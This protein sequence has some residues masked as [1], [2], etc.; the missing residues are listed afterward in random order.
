MTVLRARVTAGN[1]PT[2]V[3]MLGFEITDWAEQGVLADLTDLASKEGWDKVVPPALQKFSK[4]K[5]KW[6]AAP[7]NVHSTN[8]VWANKKMLRPAPA[9]AADRPGTSS[10]P[11]STRSRR[12]ATSR[13]RTA[14][15][16]G[17]KRPSSTVVVLPTGGPD[18]YR[19]AL[20]RSRPGRARRRPDEDG[21]R[22]AQGAG[23]VCRRQRCRAATGTSRPRWS[24]ATRPASRSWATGPRASSSTPRSAGQG[25][26]VLPLPGHAGDVS[27]NSDQFAMFN[28]GRASTGRRN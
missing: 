15:S 8:W 13:S 24:S 23:L 25:L 2:A 7:V 20:Y 28:V 11:R 10:S 5:G 1:P 18:F 17:R 14:A 21:V 4:Y 12:P 22:A 9:V 19:K 3:Q 6:V 16:R 27:F 26:P